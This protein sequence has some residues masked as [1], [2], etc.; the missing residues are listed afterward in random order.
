M[1]WAVIDRR[2]SRLTCCFTP[3]RKHELQRRAK[4][5]AGRQRFLWRVWAAP[6][7]GH[8]IAGEPLPVLVRHDLQGLVVILITERQ[9]SAINVERTAIH[10]AVRRKGVER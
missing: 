6:A 4:C 1:R 3:G 7:S 10:R 9:C 5:L 8:L 2:Y